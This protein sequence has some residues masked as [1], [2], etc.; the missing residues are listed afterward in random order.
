MK[1]GTLYQF[2]AGMA[3]FLDRFARR[4]VQFCNSSTD[5]NVI[6]RIT[7]AGRR[8]ITKACI[9]KQGRVFE[10]FEDNFPASRSFPY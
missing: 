2:T 4:D 10:K 9:K 5:G 1:K 7:E 6:Y 3:P 8:R